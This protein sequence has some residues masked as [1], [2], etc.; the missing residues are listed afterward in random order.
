MKLIEK[1]N[2]FLLILM[3]VTLIVI[4]MEYPLSNIETKKC[5]GALKG[6]AMNH[7]VDCNVCL[8]SF[9]VRCLLPDV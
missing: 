1:Q 7:V 2:A 5:M 3:V 9:S 8:M 4:K 6:A